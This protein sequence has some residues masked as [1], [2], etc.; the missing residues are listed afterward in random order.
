MRDYKLYPPGIS[1]PT[2]ADAESAL[3]E[4]ESLNSTITLR[5]L[6]IR[7]IARDNK[8]D[9]W[10]RRIAR[11]TTRTPPRSRSWRAGASSPS[12]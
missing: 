10:P 3:A 11:P 12:K 1:F 4:A 2:I 8:A 7:V 5:G 9:E 6:V